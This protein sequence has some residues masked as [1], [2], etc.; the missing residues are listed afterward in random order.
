MIL[1]SMLSNA[2]NKIKL[3]FLFNP[4][5]LFNKELSPSLN[6]KETYFP[7]VLCNDCRILAFYRY[8]FIYLLMD[9]PIFLSSN[10]SILTFIVVYL[11]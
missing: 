6:T 2:L 4:E 10:L 9:I 5:V 11:P 3:N 8:L 1:L 7:L